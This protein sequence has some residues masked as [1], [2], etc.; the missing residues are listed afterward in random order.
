M[1]RRLREGVCV[2]MCLRKSALVWLLLWWIRKGCVV[3][4]NESSGAAHVDSPNSVCPNVNLQKGVE[5]F[6]VDAPR[7]RNHF[8]HM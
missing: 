6:S 7:K 2:S 4:P 1:D 8:I 5:Q 3:C